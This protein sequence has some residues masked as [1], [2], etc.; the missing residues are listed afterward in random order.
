MSPE[1][2]RWRSW[3]AHAAFGTTAANLASIALAHSFL[4]GG[5]ALLLWRP[6]RVRV[7]AVGWPVLALLAWTLVAVAF[8]ADPSAALPQIKKFAV[9]ATLPLVYTAF[10]SADAC[11]RAAQA[12]FIVALASSAWALAQF[13]AGAGAGG[14]LFGLLVSRRITGFYSHWMTF[15]QVLVI[16][17]LTLCCYLLFARR[18]RA[19]GV[20]L[21][22]AAIMTA[23]LVASSTR[24]AWLAM[25]A[26][27]LYLVAVARPRLLA[28][29]P[30]IVALAYLAAPEP[31]QRRI[32]SIRPDADP[33]RIAMWSAGLS[34]IESR[35]LVGV[36]PERAGPSFA[37][38]QPDDVGELPPGFYGHLHNVY[39]HFAAER[40][41][42][43]ALIVVWLFA[44]VL[45]DMRRGLRSVPDGRDDRR[46]L[47]HAGIAATLA[48]G[49]LSCFDVTLGDSEVLAAY[50]AVV[51]VAYRGL[52]AVGGRDAG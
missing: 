18:R 48:V 24:S 30:V 9:F 21:A 44:Q 13:A 27:A 52:P 43:A 16:V 38:H 49:V 8:S 45:L 33:A 10:R 51:A 32:E 50:L 17:L 46:F 41:L 28:A 42:P 39:I 5:I 14:E 26:G 36:G 1:R 19:V 15:S 20:W 25:L 22:A 40:G 11:Q 47:L 29:V 6:R 23:A 34:M 4:A 7:P 12:W 2:S 37:E 3:V 31:L 35:P